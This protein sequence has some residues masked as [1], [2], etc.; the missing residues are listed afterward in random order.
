MLFSMLSEGRAT[1]FTTVPKKSTAR[2]EAG[3]YYGKIPIKEQ[4]PKPIFG[5]C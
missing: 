1:S 2:L 4:P 3:F 5:G